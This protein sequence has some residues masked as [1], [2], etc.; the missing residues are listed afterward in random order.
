MIPSPWLR[1][2]RL[3]LHSIGFA[4]LFLG[5]IVA[6]YEHAH[7][8]GM[9]FFLSAFIGLLIHLVTAFVNDL[10]DVRSDENNPSRSLFSGGS[11]VIVDGLLPRSQL[12]RGAGWA[13]FLSLVLTGVLVIGLRVHWGI[14][15]FLGWG[16]ISSLGYS[17]P[18]LKL[19]YRGGGELLVLVTY[20][21]ALVWT[22]YFVQ[23]GPIP[24]R[25]P[26]IL[27]LPIGFAVFALIAIT[28]FPDE[29]ADRMAGKRSLVILLGERPTLGLIAAAIILSIPSVLVPLLTGAVPVLA[30]VF[31]LL[32]LPLACFLLTVIIRREGGI[33]MI[34]KL[35]QGTIV[36]TL[37]YG[38]TPAFG[39]ILAKWLR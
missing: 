14:F 22:G 24:S 37:W 7:F 5:N 1:A 23:A 12:V 15:L 32:V 6:W 33:D 30:G 25:L 36:L 10:A 17:L 26:W 19:S 35:S 9:R 11:G 39:L 20:S 27:S 8:S 31:S 4:P 21:V 13:V 34:T 2:A 3:Q 29:E 28:Q 38:F 16:L 18:P